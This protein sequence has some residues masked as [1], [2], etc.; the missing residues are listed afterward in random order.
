MVENDYTDDEKRPAFAPQ[1]R[2]YRA[3]GQW[4]LIKTNDE[5]RRNA[6]LIRGLSNS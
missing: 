2:D 4:T 6:E 5:E 1:S 3:A